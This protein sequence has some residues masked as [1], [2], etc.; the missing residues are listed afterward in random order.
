ML[1]TRT[2]LGKAADPGPPPPRRVA[3]G[4]KKNG[5]QRE[6]DGTEQ[7]VWLEPHDGP[8]GLERHGRRHRSRGRGQEGTDP[9]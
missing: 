2:G 9:C 7:G 5:M 1:G 4:P 3:G 8:R 6:G